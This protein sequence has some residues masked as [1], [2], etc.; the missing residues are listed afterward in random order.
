MM[1]MAC[2]V[3]S[4]LARRKPTLVFLY[5]RTLAPRPEPSNGGKWQ[6]FERFQTFLAHSQPS[7]FSS[8]CAHHGILCRRDKAV[9]ARVATSSISRRRRGHDGMG[10]LAGQG[11]LHTT[12]VRYITFGRTCDEC[13][14]GGMVASQPLEE[15][16]TGLC[17]RRS[18]MNGE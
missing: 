12:W 11:G 4:F 2:G 17:D 3:T 18:S 10:K 6:F 16:R 5:I 15:G 8:P 9:R 7:L 1:T 14:G 13:D